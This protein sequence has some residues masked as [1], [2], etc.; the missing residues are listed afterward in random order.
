MSIKNEEEKYQKLQAMGGLS[1]IVEG[2]NSSS[3][4]GIADSEGP[5][6]ADRK[7]EYG[8][9]V[10]PKAPMAGFIQVRFLFVL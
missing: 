7:T 10:Y 5:E 1:A 9:N 3:T 8:I 4:D 6:Y 2:L